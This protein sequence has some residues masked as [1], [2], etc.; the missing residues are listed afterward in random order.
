MSRQSTDKPHQA[1]AVV[2]VAVVV[3]AR[4]RAVHVGRVLAAV[5]GAVVLIGMGVWFRCPVVG[6]T[7]LG[8]MVGG[9][10]E[11]VEAVAELMV[12]TLVNKQQV[13]LGGSKFVYTDL[14]VL[15]SIG[16]DCTLVRESFLSSAIGSTGVAPS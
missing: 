1:V 7:C 8:L 6:D 12:V 5:V 13:E 14:T 16:T 9:C 4:A 2:A 11:A 10:V 3:V 15:L